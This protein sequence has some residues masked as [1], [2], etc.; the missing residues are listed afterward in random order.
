MDNQLGMSRNTSSITIPKTKKNK[1]KS[2]KE[3]KNN[4]KSWS[5]F[6]SNP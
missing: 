5:G 6:R 1:L 2:E 3:K 4:Q